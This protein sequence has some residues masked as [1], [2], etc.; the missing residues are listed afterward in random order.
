[1]KQK[2]CQTKTHRISVSLHNSHS[3]L[4]LERSNECG[5]RLRA[6]PFLLR[7]AELHPERVKEELSAARPMD[8]IC[9][10]PRFIF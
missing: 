1:M 4:V 9:R 2:E 5:S 8:A 7:S 10:S 3:G 6:N